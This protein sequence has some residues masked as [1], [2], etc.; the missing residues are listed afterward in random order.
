MD[1]A[2]Q[3]S[4]VWENEDYNQL[5]AVE[6]H[7]C[8]AMELKQSFKEKNLEELDKNLQNEIENP[9]NQENGLGDWPQ[10]ENLPCFR[11]CPK[12]KRTKP[13]NEQ[14]AELVNALTEVSED[15]TIHLNPNIE[16]TDD[17]KNLVSQYKSGGR[18]Q[19]GARYFRCEYYTDERL[20]QA[21]EISSKT[22]SKDRRNKGVRTKCRHWQFPFSIE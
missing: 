12:L 11:T 6:T 5:E 18:A 19:R 4:S 1:L 16:I 20:V 3:N 7:N 2:H 21:V 13:T 14:I 15:K 8:R 22:I 10:L 9:S 17:I